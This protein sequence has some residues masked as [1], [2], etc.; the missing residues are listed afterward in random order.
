VQYDGLGV[1]KEHL[2][3]RAENSCTL[4]DVSHMG[5]IKS[6]YVSFIFASVVVIVI[7]Y[8]SSFTGGQG[9]MQ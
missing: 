3:T 1:L 5:Q 7:K 4:F 9:R 6:V 2:H 8:L